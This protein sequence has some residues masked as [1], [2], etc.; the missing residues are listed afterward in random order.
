MTNLR[1]V[2]GSTW[3]DYVRVKS[4]TK[5]SV[6]YKLAVSS[7]VVALSIAIIYYLPGWRSAACR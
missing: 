1:Q 2:I 6:Q 5:F 4:K 7:L 3:Y